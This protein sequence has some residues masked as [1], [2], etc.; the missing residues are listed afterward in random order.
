MLGY[1]KILT[2]GSMG[3]ERA[4]VG[5]VVVQEKVDG[6]QFRFGMTT[7]GELEF[8]SR[9]TQLFPGAVTKMFVDGVEYI[10]SI[11]DRMED[12]RDV[13]FFAEYLQKPKHNALKYDRIPKNHLMLFDVWDGMCWA[14]GSALKIWTDFLNIDVVPELF[15]GETTVD[16]L[17]E[18]HKTESYL[19]GQKVEGVVVK[20]YHEIM[21]IG[22]TTFPVF[23]K[24]VRQKF[25]ELNKTNWRGHSGKSN[26]Q[27]F[28][29]SFC[30]EARWRKAVQH[31]KE[32]GDL[33]NM[34][35][36][37]GPLM[38]EVSRDIDAEETENIKEALY[39]LYARD[40]KRSATRGLPEWYKSSLLERI[41]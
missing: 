5:S 6:S 26:L 18:L 4:L 3:T 41:E 17:I 16:D 2:L 39:K 32:S 10:T 27:E 13:W 30:T 20:N 36:D 33:Q 12:L 40:I 37:I 24:L 22:G 14:T 11:R 21:A 34:P 15:V 9:R 28:L 1:T 19:G 8:A 25:K 31:L 23:T 35:Q 29:E 7:D 38:R